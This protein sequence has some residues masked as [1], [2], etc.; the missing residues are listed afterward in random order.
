MEKL[1]VTDRALM[2][3]FM[4]AGN[5]EAQVITAP[6]PPH[7]QNWLIE[8]YPANLFQISVDDLLNLKQRDDVL[9]EIRAA[10]REELF[11]RRT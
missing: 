6:P 10:W 7:F 8:M 1:L 11:R 5:V 2:T 4:F 3:I 9:N